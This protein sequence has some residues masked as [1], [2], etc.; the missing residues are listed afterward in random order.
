MEA[1]FYRAALLAAVL[2]FSMG[3]SY[4]TP[5]FVVQTPDPQLAA[6][7][8][9]A[10]EKFRKEL[11]ASWLGQVLPNWAGPCVM[12][13]RVGNNLGAGGATTFMFRDGEVFGWRMDI[14]GSRERI[15]DSVLPHEI[16]H[17]ILASHFRCPLPRWADEGAATSVEHQSEKAKHRR[18]L[19]QFLRT[20]RGIPFNQMFAMKDYPRDVMPL[21]AQGFSLAEYLIQQGGRRK[22]IAYIEDGLRTKNWGHTTQRHYGIADLGQLQTTWLAW[23]EQGRPSRTAPASPTTPAPNTRPSAVVLADAGRRPRPEPNLIHHPSADENLIRPPL[24]PVN[25]VASSSTATPVAFR[26]GSTA[27]A[28]PLDLPLASSS[29]PPYP[30]WRA[31]GSSPTAPAEGTLLASRQTTPSPPAMNQMARPQSIEP[32]RPVI[33]EWQ[34]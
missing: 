14:Q 28:A 15:F 10:A 19:D 11:A 5:N 8:G 18:M 34:R 24:V 32:S 16:T 30:S 3:A 13:V 1:R 21:Y 23:V 7:I 12:N 25:Y 22:F 4:R 17:M 27:T 29:S 33:I 26:P 20:D 31:R 6:Q 2:A 9:Q